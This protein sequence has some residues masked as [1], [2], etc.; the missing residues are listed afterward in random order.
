MFI[1]KKIISSSKKNYKVILTG[2]YAGF[3]KKLIN[4]NS[5]IDTNITIKGIIKI[6]KE[7]L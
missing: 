2:G 5:I 4:K 7:L 6:Y 3:F 1:I